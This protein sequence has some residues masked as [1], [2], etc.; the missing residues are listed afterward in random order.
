MRFIDIHSHPGQW[1]GNHASADGGNLIELQRSCGFLATTF[2]STAA[3]MGEVLVGNAETVALAEAYPDAY[4]LLLPNPMFWDE[5]MEVLRRWGNHEKV[6]GIKIHPRFARQPITSRPYLRLLEEIERIGLPVCTHSVG[7]QIPEP[8]AGF[9]TIP[10]IKE[11]AE[12]FPNITFVAYHLGIHDHLLSGAEAVV[13]CRTG[14]LYLD[15]ANPELAYR[16]LLESVVEVCGADRVLFGSDSPIHDPKAMR[17]AIE[18]SNLSDAQKEL[19]A[20]KN[21][22]RV[23]PRLAAHLQKSGL[24]DEV[25]TS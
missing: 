12:T 23:M 17:F 21:A 1:L 14:N 25:A 11:V 22:L 3:M 10:M 18:H 2:S 7:T 24:L 8:I 19:I 5:S 9:C 20:H 4:V 6:V 13:A 16:G 15:T